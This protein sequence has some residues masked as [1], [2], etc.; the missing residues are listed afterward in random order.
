MSQAVKT[1]IAGGSHWLEEYRKSF[2]CRYI[3]EN[4]N[5]LVDK[6]S[7]TANTAANKGCSAV[8]RN[9]PANL[10]EV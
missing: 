5:N 4:N 6:Q 10:P 7:G 2:T 1:I 8:T 9:K 3:V